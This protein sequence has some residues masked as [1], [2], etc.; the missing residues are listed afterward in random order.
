MKIQIRTAKKGDG[1]GISNLF[2]EGFEKNFY[3]YTG[4]N[5]MFN[6]EKIKK[7]EKEF[8]DKSSFW[9]IAVDESTNKI[10]GSCN[11]SGRDKGRTRHRVECGW[12]VHPNYIKKGIA[13]KMMK[14]II[15]EAKR[16]K[17]KKI[18][19]EAAV[20][21]KSSIQLAK[22]IGFKIEGRKKKGLLL[23]NGKYVDTY[24]FGKVFN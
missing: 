7:I 8:S 5:K 2:N 19:A 24:I 4:S 12:F 15:E 23:D 3:I 17:L 9:V 14:K 22:K 11:F 13:T 1:K 20:I 21:N 6:K 10:V 18:E 16:R